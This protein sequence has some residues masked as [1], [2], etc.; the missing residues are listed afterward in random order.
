MHT[1]I[2]LWHVRAFLSFSPYSL[3]TACSFPIYCTITRPATR[4]LVT[5]QITKDSQLFHEL[6]NPWMVISI[7]LPLLPLLAKIFGIPENYQSSRHVL[8]I[9]ILSL[10]VYS[11]YTCMYKCADGVGTPYK[12]SLIH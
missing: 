4:L 12:L 6:M 2:V 8:D 3:F 7:D 10:H 1:T 9:I 11:T 5:V